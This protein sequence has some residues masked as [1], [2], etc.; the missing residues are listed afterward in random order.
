M[1]GGHS[2]CPIVGHMY[3][4]LMTHLYQ[5]QRSIGVNPERLEPIAVAPVYVW[6]ASQPGHMQDTPWADLVELVGHILGVLQAGSCACVR[7]AAL[8]EQRD[9]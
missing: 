9:D 4:P 7:I 3:A 6:R 8:F 1:T 2:T 5:I